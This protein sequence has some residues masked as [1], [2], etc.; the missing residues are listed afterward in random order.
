MAS[1]GPAAPVEVGIVAINDFHG[2]SN[3]RKQSVPVGRRP[4][5][6]S[7][8]VPAGG[9]AWLAS[10]IDSIRAKYPNHLTVSAGDL[11]GGSQLVSALYLD[12][13]TIGAMNRI[14]LDFNAVG[15]HEFDRGQ[16]GTAAQA[17]RRL[18]PAHRAQALPG[19][20]VQGREVHVP[21]RQHAAAP[22]ARTL[23]PGTALRSFGTGAPQGHGRADRRDAEGHRQTWSR[24]TA[25]AGM[26]FADEADTINAA[27]AALKAQGADAIVVLIHQGGRTSRR[28]RSAGLRRRSTGAILP[29]LDRLDPRVDVVVS[30]HTHW[31][32]VCDYAARR[33]RPAV[34]ADQRRGVRRTGHRHPPRDRSGQRPGDRQG[35][36]ATSSS[37]AKATSPRAGRSSRP[38]ASRASPPRADI[39]AYVAQLCRGQPRVRAAPGGRLGGTPTRPQG[40]QSRYGGTL[41]NLIADAQLAASAGAGAQIAFMNPFGIRA[42]HTLIPAADGSLTFGQIYAVQ[43]FNNDLVT[44]TLTG[45]QIKAVL[46]QCF[47]GPDPISVLTPSQGLPTAST[48]R[49]PRATGWWR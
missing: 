24:P 25:S 17:E 36:R 42:P 12:E 7:S 11:I 23:F 19:R 43:P 47:S 48:C 4:M 3:R 44:K 33:S 21:R 38:T 18:R 35:S 39:A 40:D 37:R 20:A 9:A 29:I 8:Q 41:G 49:G 34:P 5:A 30:G 10:A 2:A 31:A 27:V 16:R 28:A 45:A 46:E 22:T 15:N 6:R 14:G 26:T 1:R 13:P 32:Y